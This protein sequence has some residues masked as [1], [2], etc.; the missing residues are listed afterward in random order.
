MHQK[1]SWQI[2]YKVADMIFWIISIEKPTYIPENK[3]FP[4]FNPKS[5]VE[6][7]L[8]NFF[9]NYNED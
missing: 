8:F 3:R 1:G 7:K 6:S 5:E 4:K 2:F 9:L